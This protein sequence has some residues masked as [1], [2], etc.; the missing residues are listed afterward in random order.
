MSTTYIT[1]PAGILDVLMSFLSLVGTSL[2]MRS[3]WPRGLCSYYMQVAQFSYAK[4]L[5]PAFSIFSTQQLP[6]ICGAAR[7]RISIDMGTR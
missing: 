2:K 5:E 4:V 7:V 6:E 3:S 1:V